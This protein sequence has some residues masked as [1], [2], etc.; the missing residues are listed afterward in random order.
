VGKSCLKVFETIFPNIVQKREVIFYG[1][2]DKKGYNVSHKLYTLKINHQFVLDEELIYL[3]IVD[4]KT[5]KGF[6][7]IVD[8]LDNYR[9][10]LDIY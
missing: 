1:G 9:Y 3:Q 5:I 2:L 6:D 10:F 7:P 8:Y 4:L